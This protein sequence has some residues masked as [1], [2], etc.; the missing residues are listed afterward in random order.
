MGS[1]RTSGRPVLA[2][3][4]MLHT[5]SLTAWATWSCT[6]SAQEKTTQPARDTAAKARAAE[7]FQESVD[8]YRKGDFRTTIALLQE[9]YAL[10]PQP[11]LLYN[12]AR[13]YEGVGDTD[14]AI[15]AYTRYLALDPKARDRG[16]IEQRITTLRRAR[17]EKIALQKQSDVDRRNA[18]E[19]AK[20][21][22]KE[23]ADSD[24][25]NSSAA[26]KPHH[27]SAWPYVIGGVGLAGL[28]AGSVFGLMAL[29]EHATAGEERVQQ[30]AA[31]D[32]SKAQ[33][34]ATTSTLTLIAG[35]ALLAIGTTWWIVDGSGKS[36]RTTAQVGL[37]LTPSGVWLR[38]QFE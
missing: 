17:D 23:K 28:A 24:A 3:L 4:F 26:S 1:G 30:T 35:G 20:R 18:Q 31:D 38:G 21:S 12:L 2:L 34:L 19:Q 6:A 13:A 8:S 7:L 29:S 11:V 33:I 5:S 15:D 37:G 32:Q 36:N 9:A 16:A 14:S 25:K 27:R 10:D 22:A